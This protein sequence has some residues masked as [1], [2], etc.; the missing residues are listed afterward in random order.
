MKKRTAVI[1]A[2]MVVYRAG[3]ASEQEIKWEDDIWTLH[4]SEA[5]MK[6]IVNDMVEYAVDQTKA[7]DYLMVFSDKRN[8]RYDIFP[9]Y[10][11]NRKGK[12][13]PLGLAS[14]TDWAFNNHNGVRKN[15]LEADDVIGMMCCGREDMVAVSG[16]KD[17]G[18]LNCEWFN[19]LKAE[20]S[21]TTLEE[22]NYNHMVQT[23]SGDS[24]DGFS[25]AKGIGPK[26]AMKL[27]DKHGATW[28]T[29]LDAYA[30]KGQPE[31]DALMN[32]RLSYIL[33]SPKEYNEK[34]GE[35]KLWNPQTQK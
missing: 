29:V 10:K 31:E 30:D 20:T 32:A 18:T 15:N 14:I 21:L 25:G 7:S 6:V 28:N 27:L 19:F 12:R 16:D 26:T 22:A 33:R 5:D 35:I 8:F 3:F 13:K 24:V 4:S 17:F 1:D 9:E 23:L 11:A 2:D 34:E